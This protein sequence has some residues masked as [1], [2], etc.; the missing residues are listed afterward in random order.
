MEKEEVR[1]RL[2]DIFNAGHYAGHHGEG[3]EKED[4]IIDETLQFIYC[5]V[6]MSAE[7]F[8]RN[9]FPNQ[10]MDK[11]FMIDT[12]RAVIDWEDIFNA[13]EEYASQSSHPSTESSDSVAIAIIK[14]LIPMAED[15]YDFHKRNGVHQEFLSEDVEIISKANI[16]ITSTNNNK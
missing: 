6:G 15:A 8:L 1:K 14:K 12:G 3:Y 16:F 10:D 13:M 7:E 9:K 5:N 4:A 11:R 2:K